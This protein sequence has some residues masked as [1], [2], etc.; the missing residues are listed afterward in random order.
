MI[1]IGAMTLILSPEN[2]NFVTRPHYINYYKRLDVIFYYAGVLWT[3]HLTPPVLVL[4]LVGMALGLWKRDRRCYFFLIWIFV[5]YFVLTYAGTKT[6]R[7]A[8]FWIPAFCLFAASLT[9][10][11]SLRYWKVGMATVLLII[12]GVQFVMAYNLESNFARGYKAAAQYV[13]DHKKGEAILYSAYVDTGYF[14]FHI[15]ASDSDRKM[16]VLRADKLLATSFLFW[17]LDDRIKDKNEIYKVLNDFGV[18]HVVLEDTQ[19]RIKP[20]EWLREEVQK[21]QFVLKKSIPILSKDPRLQ[22]ISL[23]IYEYKSCGPPN[24]E[25]VLD[26]N[27]PLINRSIK[28][29]F[30]ELV[31]G[32]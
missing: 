19:Y 3:H 17:N 30:D 31:K 8:I 6:P 20:L 25:A 14:I 7:Y 27:L 18:C 9:N 29:R 24:P 32:L 26:M 11:F 13:M 1:P 2:V 21:D 28:V 12:S 22:G 5:F 16:I 10:Y 23:K 4:S 15:R